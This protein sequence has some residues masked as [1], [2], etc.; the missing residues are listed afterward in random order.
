ML[1][2][3]LNAFGRFVAAA[4]L[5]AVLVLLA[6]G[7]AGAGELDPEWSRALRPGSE[8]GVYVLEKGEEALLARAWL[9]D[10]ATESIDVQYFIWST[11]NVGILAAESLLRA[12]ERGVRVRV[13]VDDLL[14]DA[15]PES[16]VALAAH[17]NIRI[18]IYNPVHKTGVS[19]ARRLLN[20]LTDFRNF[21]QRMHDKTF[22]VDGTFAITGGRNMADE[23]FDYD[24]KY[25]FRDRDLLVAGAV[26]PAIKANFENFWASPLSVPVE[27]LL[28]F[29]KK[30]TDTRRIRE[31]HAELHG[32]A[33]S[34]ENFAPEVR[35][36][37]EHLPR[38]FP[39]LLKEMVWTEARFLHDAPGKNPGDAGLGGGGASTQALARV[40]ATASRSVLIQSPYLVL[41]Q[42]ALELFRELIGR[43]V[44]VR[45]V[46]NSLGS[47][48]NLA[49]FSGYR[50]QRRQIL[51]AGIQVFEFKP[52][53][54][55]QQELIERYPSLARNAP[56]F[57]I[58]S[59]TMVLD[60]RILFVGTFN[61]DPRS[62]NLN[63][64]VGILLENRR[65]AEQVAAAIRNDMA[66]ENSW[67]AG[68]FDADSEAPLGKR[69]RLRLWE[70][71][72]LEAL[73]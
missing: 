4:F 12:A 59:K 66:P 46:T 71:L 32:Y 11:D 45:I 20:L 31:V 38:K 33:R 7:V 24:Q 63:T 37:L 41:P 65:L 70:L 30:L 2:S 73:L 64:E 67:R 50:K 52:H 18:R 49:A 53:P 13:I 22:T 44:E 56:I 8:T 6:P 17:P 57:A 16:L 5:I 54:K 58:H 1:F 3:P 25:N 51:A 21:N 72:P 14:L 47:T 27:E 9:A 19:K 35:Q 23:Y 48:D 10:W 40:V 26:I 43:G 36:A 69:L 34:P 68:A 15:S 55:I 60:D 61:L 42:G 28:S 62:A 39:R 29:Q